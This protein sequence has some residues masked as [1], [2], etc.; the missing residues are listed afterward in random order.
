MKATLEIEYFYCPLSHYEKREK[1]IFKK[2]CSLKTF[3]SLYSE[4]NI[5]KD[6]NRYIYLTL[7]Q[8]HFHLVE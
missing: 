2:L 5:L 4:V 1:K 6:I 7:Y 8:Y 3:S